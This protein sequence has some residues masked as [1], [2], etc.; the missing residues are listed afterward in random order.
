MTTVLS[1]G[2]E[3][4]DFIKL[5]GGRPRLGHA[6]SVTLQTQ[7]P[8]STMPLLSIESSL[9]RVLCHAWYHLPRLSSGESPEWPAD[10]RSFV[11]CAYIYN[12][13][14]SK[15]FCYLTLFCMKLAYS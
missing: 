2:V 3:V 10:D 14:D 9:L 12:E 15:L 13:E 4:T 5:R 1:S 7:D 6:E 11:F 8:P